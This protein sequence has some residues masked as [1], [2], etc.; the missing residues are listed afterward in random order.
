MVDP[1]TI[2]WDAVGESIPSALSYSGISSSNGRFGQE[3]S[4][5]EY[6]FEIS[7]PGYR[8]MRTH[9]GITM[10][11]V[12]RANINLDPVNLPTELRDDV[13][14]SELRDGYELVH[15]YIVDGETHLPMA[16]VKLRRQESDATSVSD[17]RGY[18]QLYAGAISTENASRPEDFPEADTLTA[19]ASGYKTYTLTGLLHMSGSHTVLRIAMAPGLGPQMSAL[20]TGHCCLLVQHPTRQFQQRTLSRKLSATG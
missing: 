5:S 11:S 7:A 4:Q 15:G 10:G 17:S 6:A 19:T 3:L 16:G 9:F 13:V 12:V 2:K 20:T 18:F 1:T 14:A 8:P